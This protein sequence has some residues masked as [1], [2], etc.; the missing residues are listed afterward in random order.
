MGGVGKIIKSVANIAMQVAPMLI[1]GGQIFGMAQNLFGVGS[2]LLGGL[3]K[4]A[5]KFF[6]GLDDKLNAFKGIAERAMGKASEFLGRVGTAANETAATME[7]AR[8][9]VAQGGIGGM[10]Q[11]NVFSWLR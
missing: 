5:P 7:R 4:L 8:Q 10:I 11:T 1:P 6:Q 3:K 9:P 2:Q